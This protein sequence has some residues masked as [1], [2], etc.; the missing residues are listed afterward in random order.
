MVIQQGTATTFPAG[1]YRF[2]NEDK[3]GYY[4]HA[5][6]KVL[7]DDVGVYAYEGGLYVRRGASGPTDWYLIKDGQTKISRFKKIPPY[8][9]VP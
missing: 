1:Q 2:E 6:G 7:E 8:K 4:F 9:V 5:P 3:R